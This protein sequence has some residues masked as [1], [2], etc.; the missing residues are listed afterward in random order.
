MLYNT[1]HYNTILPIYKLSYTACTALYMHYNTI[2]R[3]MYMY[4]CNTYNT[5]HCTKLCY[6]FLI[7]THMYIHSIMYLTNIHVY[8]YR[9]CIV[10]HSGPVESSLLRATGRGT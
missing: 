5:T 7:Y 2:L 4:R 9:I 10:W 6:N 3:Y 8:V 1:L